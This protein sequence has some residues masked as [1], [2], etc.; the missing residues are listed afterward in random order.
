VRLTLN[1]PNDAY[2]V[3]VEDF[4]P[5][6]AEILDVRL[7]TSQQARAAAAGDHPVRSGRSVRK[8]LGAWLFHEPALFD[9]HIAWAADY[10]PKGAYELT[11]SFVPL[12]AGEF[13]CCRRTPGRRIS[14]RCRRP[15]QEAGLRLSEN[16]AGMETCLH[17]GEKLAVAR[18]PFLII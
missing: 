13:Q 2:Y 10:L 6:G 12:Q 18:P 7:K 16:Q 4:I 8:W 1:V 15:A 17:A 14:R 3:R 9:D 5:A 11:Y